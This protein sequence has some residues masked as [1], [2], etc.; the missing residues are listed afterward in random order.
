[1]HRTLDATAALLGIGPRKLRGRL[2][3][4]GV[5]NHAGELECAH[6][7]TGRFFVDCRSRW[8]RS[9]NGWSHYGV[10]MTTEAGVAWIAGQLGIEVRCMP[11]A[12]A[13]A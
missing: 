7:D 13:T 10:V 2:R 5:L 1:M 6:R 11:P 9:I 3:D 8:N 4:L 12:S